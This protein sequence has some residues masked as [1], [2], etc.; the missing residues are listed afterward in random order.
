[1]K[2]LLKY[3]FW[4]NE[5]SIYTT[6]WRSKCCQ[7]HSF[8]RLNTGAS[9]YMSWRQI[10]YISLTVVIFWICLRFRNVEITISERQVFAFQNT[11]LNIGPTLYCSTGNATFFCLFLPRNQFTFQIFWALSIIIVFVNKTKFVKVF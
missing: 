3:F 5:T 10:W 2:H 9:T 6:T 8:A 11:L 4:I 1:M 7:L